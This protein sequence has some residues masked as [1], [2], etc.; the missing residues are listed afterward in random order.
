[1]K[2]T[3]LTKFEQ[4]RQTISDEE[5]ALMD[6][7]FVDVGR[8]IA[9]GRGEKSAMLA[10]FENA[11]LYYTDNG[12][13]LCDALKRMDVSRMG[14]FY[15]RPPK[16]WYSLDDAAKVYP[17]SMKHGQMAVFRLS[18]YLDGDIVPELLQLALCFTIKR[19][20]SFAT[21]VKAGMFWHYLD[22]SKRRYIIEP[23]DGMPCKPL[24]ISKTC[25]QSFRVLYYNN[26]ISVEYF[27]ILTDGSGGMMFLKTLTAEYLRL[28]GVEL[29][30]CEHILDINEAPDE[31]EVSNAFSKFE[32]SSSG[33]GFVDKP[34]VQMSGS[35]SK[36]KPCRVLHFKFDATELKLAAKKRGATVTTYLLALMFLA[37]RYATDGTEGTVNMQVP[38][39]MRKFYPSKTLRNFSLYCG[40]RLPLTDITGIEEMLPEITE[41][42]ANKG[43]KDAMSDMMRATSDMVN[44]VRFVPLC[45]KSPVAQLIYGF[46]GDK[47]FSNTL[48]NLGVVRLPD[49]M[50]KHVKSMD[51]VLGTSI[52][53]RASC[54]LVTVNNTATFTISKYTVDPSFEEKLYELILAEGLEIT[55]EGSELYED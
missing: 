17:I 27:H 48:S 38:I 15:A 22:A 10:D 13:A 49:E 43:S 6:E 44:G 52:T 26:R 3:R 25:S 14:G 42:L 47:I 8:H 11:I 5:I 23:D 53:N 54:A 1:M 55:V 4:F 9:L 7:Y 33:S 36:S 46:L 19:F 16:L 30:P 12:V 51:F 2:I 39:N 34:S 28:C 21:T 24:N 35:I 18:A 45:I 50:A 41:Q 31:E 20:P 40:V 37:Q 29:S 32:L